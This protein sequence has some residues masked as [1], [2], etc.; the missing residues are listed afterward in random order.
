MSLISHIRFPLI[1][2]LRALIDYLETSD[3]STPDTSVFDF[4]A[5]LEALP[6]CSYCK[7]T[8]EACPCKFHHCPYHRAKSCIQHHT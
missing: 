2:L 7:R 4:S 6:A 1:T 8:S 3:A 5:T